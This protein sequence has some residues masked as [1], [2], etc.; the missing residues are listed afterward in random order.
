MIVS[1]KRFQHEIPQDITKYRNSNFN[2]FIE[3]KGIKETIIP[4]N[5][6][7]S[8]ILLKKKNMNEFMVQFLKENNQKTLLTKEKIYEKI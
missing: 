7:P 1:E 6:V 2:Y 3:E 8:N 4:K 5:D